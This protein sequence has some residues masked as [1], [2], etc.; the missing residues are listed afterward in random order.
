M[1]VGYWN[2]LAKFHTELLKS[3]YLLNEYKNRGKQWNST[4]LLQI[5][6]EFNQTIVN[7]ERY[8][9]TTPQLNS[10]LSLSY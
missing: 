1:K 4:Q 7:I 6:T 3:T 10:Y 5:D 8:L 2:N 9:K